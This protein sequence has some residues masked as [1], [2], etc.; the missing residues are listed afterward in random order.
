MEDFRN[1][2]YAFRESRSRRDEPGEG[3][4]GGFVTLVQIVLAALLVGSAFLLKTANPE[5]YERLRQDYA[6]AITREESLEEAK[7]VLFQIYGGI[8]GKGEGES[9]SST[10]AGGSSATPSATPLPG[11]SSAAPGEAM[12]TM[13]GQGGLQEVPY[14][15][16]DKTMTPPENASYE[17]YT[18]TVTPQLPV[19][20][21]VTSPFGYRWHPITKKLDFHTG[22]DIAAAK[23]TKIAAALSGTVA[24]AGQSRVYGNYVLLRHSDDLYTFYGHCD[25][26]QVEAGTVVRQGETIGYVGSTGLSTGPHLHLEIRLCGKQVDPRWVFPQL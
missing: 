10:P 6:A 21:R 9:G 7:D 20:G 25:S 14:D 15:D 11:S 23:G 8:T 5:W 24:E 16:Y 12:E 19:S 26:L 17:P 18:L 22:V 3:P 2:S 4:G 13:G 1:R